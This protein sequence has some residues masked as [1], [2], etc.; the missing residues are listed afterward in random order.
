VIGGNIEPREIVRIVIRVKSSSDWS[1]R[2]LLRM[3]EMHMQRRTYMM[4][5]LVTLMHVHEWR[6]KKRQDESN[7][8][9]R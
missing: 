2:G 3:Q 7:A 4:L 6:L 9:Q 1:G 8:R 5:I